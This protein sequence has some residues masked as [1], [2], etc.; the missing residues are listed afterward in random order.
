MSAS[1]KGTVKNNV[2]SQRANQLS[3]SG[4]RKFFDLLASMEGVISLGVG[5]PDYATPWRIR[6]AAIYSVEKGDTMYTSNSGMPELRNGLSRYLASNYHVEYD[7]ARELLVT[8]GV[9]E[10]LDLAM[11]AII[12]PG[13]EV[14]VPDPCYVAYDACVLLAGGVP[15]KVPTFEKTNFELIAAEIES[16]LTRRTKAILLGETNSFDKDFYFR[17][18]YEAFGFKRLDY[19]YL[20]PEDGGVLLKSHY[21]RL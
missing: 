8:V 10:A 14:I 4:I 21:S 7:P 11:R 2:I 1:P 5:E 12:N 9:S 18:D 17:H 19:E 3:P 20:S 15:V 6:E 13:D 16:R